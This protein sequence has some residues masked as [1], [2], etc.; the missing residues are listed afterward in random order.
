M[1]EH[2]Y[3]CGGCLTVL[4][5]GP[6][7]ARHFCVDGSHRAG[8]PSAHAACVWAIVQQGVDEGEEP[9]HAVYGTMSIQ[10]EVQRTIKGPDMWA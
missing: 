8:V 3:R 10:V 2:N 4:G 1:S 7:R 9:W 5:I 6:E